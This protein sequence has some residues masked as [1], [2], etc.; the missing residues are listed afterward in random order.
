M[1]TE[2]IHTM[3]GLFESWTNDLITSQLREFSAHTRNEL[4]M[5]RHFVRP[6]DCLLDIG[7]HIGTFSVPFARF[8]GEA[9]RVIAFEANPANFSLL[10]KNVDLNGLLER[11]EAH[12][13]VVTCR[14]EPCVMRLGPGANSGMYFF[15][16]ARE[17]E[18]GHEVIH[19]DDWLD[20]RVDVQRIDVIKIDVEGAEMDVLRSC[21]RCILAHR[22]AIYLEINVVALSVFGASSAD[23]E[24][25]L[26]SLGYR[27][28]R[29][30]GERNSVHD[31]FRMA[32]CDSLEREG[33]FF[34][35][36]ALHRADER[37]RHA[38]RL[39]AAEA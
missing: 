33:V 35:I 14:P 9:G 16:P 27:L 6:G 5:L 30:I 18:K 1:T 31:R 20:R 26:R 24:R 32:E 19:L 23:I 4:A 12:Q 11:V 17:G 3:Y 36:L 13:G 34:D 39:V 7:A 25:H 21:S 15:V 29:N 37:C 22:P 38:E 8:A 10:R 28:F 2:F